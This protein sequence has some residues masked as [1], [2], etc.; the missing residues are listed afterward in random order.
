MLCILKI[1]LLYNKKYLL[2]HN[3]YNLNLNLITFMLHLHNIGEKQIVFFFLSHSI[4]I[5]K[6]KKNIYFNWFLK[7]KILLFE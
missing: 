2:I 3:F 7:F 4:F 6:K 5:Y 1:I